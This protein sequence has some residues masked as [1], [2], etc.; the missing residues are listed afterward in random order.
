MPE[1]LAAQRCTA[2]RPGAP[3]VGAAALQRFLADYPEWQVQ[4]IERVPQLTRLFKFKNYAQALEFTNR[5]AILA[6]AEDHHPAILL[7]WGRVTV[8]W[9]TH[10]VQ[11]LHQNDLIMAAKTSQLYQD[12]S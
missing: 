5:L 10:T 8:H 9:W 2:C 12:Y 11:G 6:E 1:D 7:E 3:P 4:E